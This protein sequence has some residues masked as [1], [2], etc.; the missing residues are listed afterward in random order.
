MFRGCLNVLCLLLMIAVPA[1]VVTPGHCQARLWSDASGNYTLEA[2]LVLS[3]DQSVVLKRADHEL[4]IIPLA[5]LSDADRE[6]LQSQE[7]ADAQKQAEDRANTLQLKNGTEIAGQIVD[8][9]KRDLTLRRWR[10][11]FYANDR[12]LD[13]L[14]EFYQQLLPHVVAHFET[15]RTVD[16]SGL[17]TWLVRQRGRP[18]TFHLEGVLIESNDGDLYAVPFF[19]LPDPERALWERYWR[20]WQTIQAENR[21]ENQEDLAFLIRSLAVAR[22]EDAQV[23]REIAELQLKL[24]AVEA[25]LTSLWEVTLYPGANVAGWPQWVVVPGRDSR[26]ATIAALQQNP[27][28]VAG[29]VRRVSRR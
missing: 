23:K 3:N 13:N 12:N 27:G 14:P 22:A 17:E 19:L 18:R 20:N 28:F 4:V 26:Q 7:A 24:Q 8:F 10:G 2:D 29:P 9:A 1:G 5:E 16:R 11:N 21:V 6:F 25:G 15:L